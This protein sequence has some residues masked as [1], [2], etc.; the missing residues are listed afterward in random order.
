MR[1]EES[2]FAIR[3]VQLTSNRNLSHI[4]GA[5]GNL[6]AKFAIA[7]AGD[8]QRGQDGDNGNRYEEFQKRKRRA[9]DSRRYRRAA[10][11]RQ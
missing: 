8:E 5:A 3:G 6:R 9:G 7:H 1:G 4:I 2:F 11:C 10:T